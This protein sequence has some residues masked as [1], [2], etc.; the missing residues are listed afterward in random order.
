M[1]ISRVYD[2]NKIDGAALGDLPSVVYKTES[3]ETEAGAC[4]VK[5]EHFY[6]DLSLLPEQRGVSLSADHT[7][8]GRIVHSLSS[9]Q[10]RW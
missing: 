2:P 4:Q 6:S 8:A 1:G 3:R 10:T 5:F 7:L 9:G